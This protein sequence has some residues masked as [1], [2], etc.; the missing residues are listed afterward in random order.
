MAYQKRDVHIHDRFD[1]AEEHLNLTRQ[2]HRHSG[3]RLEAKR[4]NEDRLQAQERLHVRLLRHADLFSRLPRKECE[5][6][7]PEGLVATRFRSSPK[8]VQIFKAKTRCVC[9]GVRVNISSS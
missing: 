6:T 3:L 1:G 7:E 4:L 5:V 2:E 8:L 9:M